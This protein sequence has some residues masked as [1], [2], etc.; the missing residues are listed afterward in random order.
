MAVENG[1]ELELSTS[2]LM[3]VAAALERFKA[4]N[5][6]L[7]RFTLSIEAQE[8]GRVIAVALVPRLFPGKRGLGSANRLGKGV[9]YRFLSEDARQIS[10]AIHR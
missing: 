3:S 5:Q 8:D 6:D 1:S 9:T 4:T 2:A 10:E 7:S